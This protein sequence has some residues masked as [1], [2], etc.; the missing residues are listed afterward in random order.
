MNEALYRRWKRDVVVAAFAQRGLHPD[1]A[2]LIPVEPGSRRRAVFTARREED[3]VVLGYH[4]PRGHELIDIA[5]CAVLQPDIVA[6]LPAL[7]ALAHAMPMRDLRLTV[8]A[9]RSG[10]DVSIEGPGNRL[11]GA[12]AAELGRIARQYA[13]ARISFAG[14]TLI[15][16]AI[17]ALATGDVE[18]V[19]PP[20][21]FVQAVEG[22]EKEMTRLV[23]AATGKSRRAAD[24]FCGI[25][26]FAFALAR[27]ARVLA[28]DANAQ[29]VT[30]LAA[31]ARLHRGLKPIETRVRDLFREPL[32][33][34]ELAA[35]DA[36]VFDPP[37]AGARDQA[38]QL[39]QSTVPTIVAVSCDAG[40][41]ARDVRILVDGGYAIESV[42]PIDQFLFSA[43]V[44]IVA[45]L[46][47]AIR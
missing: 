35:F 16:R 42:T 2:S 17:P 43:H 37:R 32:A 4:G 34:R 20:G 18:C 24:L 3:R 5:E 12:A 10:L 21:A 28:V 14:E 25:G 23:L 33:A 45:V 7:R 46:R 30:A 22:A 29:A 38:R 27:T 26:A 31:A 19:P 41:V 36:V 9:T 40:T 47:R 11:A 15:E 44:E 6:Q 13:I 8:L 1:I 39:A